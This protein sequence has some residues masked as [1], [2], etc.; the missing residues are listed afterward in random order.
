VSAQDHLHE[1]FVYPTK[2]VNGAYALPLDGAGGFSAQIKDASIETHRFP[3]GA[4]WQKRLAAA[5]AAAEAKEAPHAALSSYT[6]VY[7][8]TGAHGFIAAYTIKQ[9]LR[10]LGASAL[11]VATDVK[12]DERMWRQILSPD[13]RSAANIVRAY[14]DICDANFVAHLFTHYQPTHV[15]HFAGVQVPTCR[16]NP[17]LGSRV[18]VTGTIHVFDAA[19][20]IKPRV[21]AIVYASSAAVC[22]P[23]TAYGARAVLDNELHQPATHYGAFKLCSEANARVYWQ[24]HQIASVGLRPLTVFGVG[25]EIGLTSSPT[26]ALK[27]AVM[28]RAQYQ[29]TFNG[30]T[31]FN[32]ASDIANL[33]VLCSRKCTAG[34][35]ACNIRGQVCTVEKF[36]EIA[37]QK[38]AQKY[39]AEML[40]RFTFA[41]NAAPIPF[42]SQFDESTLATLLGGTVPCTPL[43]ESIGKCVD[44]FDR[45][46][47]EGVL[48]ESDL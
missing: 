39:G 40:C 17:A 25:R 2:I 1:H 5:A 38:L 33:F 16:A 36:L 9:L 45:L 12:N 41:K 47:T 6:D 11:I 15:L 3:N 43:E 31:A 8:I 28:R 35:L 44:H 34:A 48:D 29:V 19:V 4:L 26:K 21:K 24:D 30:E 14:G 32:D 22:S 13:E 42:P 10:D 7:L 37:A 18:N 20:K 27:A 46:K 23:A